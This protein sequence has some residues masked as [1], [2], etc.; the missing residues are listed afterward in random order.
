M[1]KRTNETRTYERYDKK[2]KA[3]IFYNYDF[4]TKMDFIDYDTG[5]T[6]LVHKYPACSKNVSAEGICFTSLKKL[7]EGENIKLELY[8][9]EQAAPIHMEG[10]IRWSQAVHLG[11]EEDSLFDTGVRLLSVE[12]KS[13]PESIHFDNTHHVLWSESLE[14]ILGKYKE[15]MK[16]RKDS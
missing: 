12:G 9:G 2:E 1:K 5:G 4:A 10:Q 13:V 14:Q 15:I 7:K 11:K 3:F 8:V 16:K 6:S